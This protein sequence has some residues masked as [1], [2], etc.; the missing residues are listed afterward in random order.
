MTS[1][2][3]AAA[4]GIGRLDD[5]GRPLVGFLVEYCRHQLGGEPWLVADA[6]FAVN[7][8]NATLWA[9]GRYLL[10]IL[11]VLCWPASR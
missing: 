8:W 10:P 6:D 9:L 2:R 5:A 4:G 3:P 11:G 1:A 7:H